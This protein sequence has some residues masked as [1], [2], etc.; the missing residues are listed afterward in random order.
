MDLWV[1]SSLPSL[2]WVLFYLQN[3]NM[4]AIMAVC[5]PLDEGGVLAQCC[6][7]LRRV[8]SCCPTCTTRHRITAATRT[9]RSCCRCWRAA[10]NLTLGQFLQ[11]GSYVLKTNDLKLKSGLCHMQNSL[12]GLS[13]L[14]FF[15]PP[16][17]YSGLCLTGCTAAC[18]EMF[19]GSSWSRSM[20]SIS[21]V[22][23]RSHTDAHLHTR[24]QA[25]T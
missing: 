13:V 21:A 10:V 5:C 3:C 20:R 7:A 18:L 11:S 23:V 2:P 15:P 17:L 24:A 6:V 25:V 1:P 12:S 4:S 16:V 9:T 8:S 22:E 19:I 14:V